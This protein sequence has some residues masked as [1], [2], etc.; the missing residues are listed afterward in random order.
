MESNLKIETMYNKKYSCPL[1]NNA[2]GKQRIFRNKGIFR[3]LLALHWIKI[4][5]PL[6][7]KYRN[8]E[9]GNV[10]DRK[11]LK[12][13]NYIKIMINYFKYLY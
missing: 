11:T 6:K 4:I 9:N 13:I 8:W 7:L 12:V 1:T 2:T 10:Y 5:Q 3:K